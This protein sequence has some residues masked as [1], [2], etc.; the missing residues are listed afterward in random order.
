MPNYKESNVSGVSWQRCHIVTIQNQLELSK[1]IDFQEEQVI[2]ING[3]IYHEWVA[4]CSKDYDAN[5]SFPIIDPT[6]GLETGQTMS[7]QDLYLALY[8][9]YIQT[10]T[11]RDEENQNGNV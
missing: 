2:D 11:E 9:L 7:H 6:T 1:K 5:A 10:A 4:G 3:K 8:S